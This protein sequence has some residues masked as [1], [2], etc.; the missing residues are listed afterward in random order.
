MLER[1]T[2]WSNKAELYIGILKGA[3]RKDLKESNCPLAFWDYCIECKVRINDLT[4]KTMFSL[5]GSNA[6]TALIG[7]EGDI[8]SLCQYAWY[9]WCYYRE[10]SAMFPFNKE[11]LGR[12]LGPASGE[13][14]EMAQWILKANGNVVPRR[15]LRPLHVDELHSAVEIKKQETFDAL[16]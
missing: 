15:L 7:E 9:D 8:S 2:R 12:V 14:N 11:I 13:V 1:N 6:H 16:I 10:Q 5:Q 3:V 4:T